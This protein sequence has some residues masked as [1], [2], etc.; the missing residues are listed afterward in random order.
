MPA[1]TVQGPRIDDLE[2]KRQLVKMF[3]DAAVQVYGIDKVHI[4]VL[5]KENPPENVGVGGQL[6]ADIHGD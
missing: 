2:L 6:M 4:F 5:I 1:I 3:T